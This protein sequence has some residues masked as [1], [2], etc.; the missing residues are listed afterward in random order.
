MHPLLNKS[1]CQVLERAWRNVDTVTRQLPL[2]DISA[3]LA[4]HT[5]HV[6]DQLASP[7]LDAAYVEVVTRRVRE[8]V[9]SSP[10][11]LD[12]DDLLALIENALVQ[13]TSEPVA[14]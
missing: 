9:N 1:Q 14:G 13:V 2:S 8:L 12:V 5:R 4:F 11:V 7:P 6:L 3:L 10:V